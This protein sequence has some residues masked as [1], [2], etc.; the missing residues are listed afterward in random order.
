MLH[1]GNSCLLAVFLAAFYRLTPSSFMLARPKNLWIVL[2]R[3]L[4]LLLQRIPD[5]LHFNLKIF[6]AIW[7]HTLGE[8][9]R[10]VSSLPLAVSGKFF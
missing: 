2:A 10:K 4:Q 1:D 5:W 3:L 9:R 7:C 8:G 6:Q